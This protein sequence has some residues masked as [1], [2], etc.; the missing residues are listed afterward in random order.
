MNNATLCSISD[1]E[2]LSNVTSIIRKSTNN[3]P[4]YIYLSAGLL[5]ILPNLIVILGVYYKKSLRKP[6]YYLLANLALCDILLGTATIF[7]IIMRALSIR[8]RISHE[9]YSIICKTLG[10]FP[11]YLSYTASIQTLV[12]ISGER[13]HAIYRP[14]SQL[15]AK[16]AKILCLIAWIISLMISFPFII[17][18]T[19]EKTALK[20]CVGFAIYTKWTTIIYL[21]LLVFQFAL[22]A[23]II[24]TLYA[25]IFHQLKKTIP[26]RNESSKSKKLKRKTIYMLL[27]TTIM[28]LIFA[29]P[30]ALTLSIIALTGK[31]PE[32]FK[33][34]AAYPTMAEF[35]RISR[36]LLPFT[37]VYNPIVYCIFNPHI[38]KLYVDCFRHLICMK[39]TVVP[40]IQVNGNRSHK[41]TE[42]SK[43][44]KVIKKRYFKLNVAGFSTSQ[45]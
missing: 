28:F 27:T 38:R 44:H 13:Y 26:G 19:V 12:I 30:W 25:L 4:L 43:T 31:L 32:E 20:R 5:G 29:A 33:L 41:S 2:K 10:I 24:I 36:T 9:V 34:H 42:N 16:K 3:Q 22:P 1:C 14:T 17:T 6:T 18:S 7:N 45:P 11:L 8:D 39:T 40:T 23:M 15:T 21:M 35:I 37:T